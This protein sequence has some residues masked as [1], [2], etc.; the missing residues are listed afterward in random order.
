[1]ESFCL[2]Q[3]DRP[4]LYIFLR[5][6]CPKIFDSSIKNQEKRIEGSMNEKV[7]EN[8]ANEHQLIEIVDNMEAL[9]PPKDASKWKQI[10]SLSLL[11][12]LMYGTV[13]VIG[14]YGSHTVYYV[15]KNQDEQEVSMVFGS[16]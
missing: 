7:E 12:K 14:I 15:I 3:S 13:A 1:M 6:D 11:K 16:L 4:D 2:L 9:L 10:T 5:T 8:K